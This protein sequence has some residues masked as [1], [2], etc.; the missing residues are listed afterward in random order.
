VAPALVIDLI[1]DLPQRR[2][3]L[4]ARYD[5]QPRHAFTTTVSS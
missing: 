5:R 2:D 4:S 3:R 1:P